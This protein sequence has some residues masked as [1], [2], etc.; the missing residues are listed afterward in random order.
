[1]DKNLQEVMGCTCLRI[2]EAARR[3]TQIYDHALEPAGL[4]VAQFGLLA[5]LSGAAFREPGGSSIGAVAQLLGIDP[6]TLNRNLKPLRARGLVKDRSNPSDRR[7]R[8]VQITEKGQRELSNAI[9]LWR[10]AHTRVEQALGR[11]KRT[12]LNDVLDHAMARLEPLE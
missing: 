8:M 10:Q 2:R 5:N 4:T 7:V 1:M 3:F 6:T 9:P 12:D 11:K